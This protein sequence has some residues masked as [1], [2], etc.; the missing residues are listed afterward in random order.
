MIRIA[1]EYILNVYIH[2]YIHACIR[3]YIHTYIR[4]YIHTQTHTHTYIYIHIYTYLMYSSIRSFVW[5]LLWHIRGYAKEAR[6]MQVH[7]AIPNL[8]FQ[9][10]NW[11]LLIISTLTLSNK[12]SSWLYWLPLLFLQL[13][14]CEKYFET[15]V[16]SF[17]K[18]FCVKSQYNAHF[19]L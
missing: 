18:E 3:T 16:I 17:G 4:T 14:V 1:T 7:T 12:Q 9:I 5:D 2:T 10:W 19:V 6:E 15:K 8:V 11:Q 13:Y